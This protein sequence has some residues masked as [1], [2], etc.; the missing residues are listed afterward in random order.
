M[1]PQNLEHRSGLEQQPV[2]TPPSGER[3]PVMPTPESGIGTG[4]ERHEQT[5]EAQA[6]ATNAFAPA[7]TTVGPVVPAV[8]VKD[9][10]AQASPMVANDDDV[11]EKEWVDK[12]KQI[13]TE[14]RDDPYERSNR[15][16]TLQKDYL[17]KRYGKELGAQP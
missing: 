7:Q 4:A 3:V 6:A 11:I 1:Q 14:T 17:K 5:A 12:A 9:S 10:S 15:V 16:N 2:P 13:I 8:P